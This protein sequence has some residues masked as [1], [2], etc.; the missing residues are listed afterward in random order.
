LS[1]MSPL[2]SPILSPPEDAGKVLVVRVSEAG[3]FSTYTLRL[4]KDDTTDNPPDGIDP[5]LGAIDFS[6]KVLCGNDF[7]CQP[8]HDCPPEPVAAPEI[9][10]LA[11]DFASF[12]QLMLDRMALMMPQWKERNPADV[13]IMLVEVL[14][15]AG[16]YLSYQQDAVGTEAY[17]GTA[18]KRISLRRHARLVD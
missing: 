8:V 13:G 2:T 18:R 16:D 12:R 7:D 3:D 5:V 14:A 9:S 1:I 10:Y 4:V 11:K 6:F 17:F 15:Y